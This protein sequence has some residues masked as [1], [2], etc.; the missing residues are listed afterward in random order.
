MVGRLA[1]VRLTVGVRIGVIRFGSRVAVRVSV[2]AMI[3]VGLVARGVNKG[4]TALA[5]AVCVP[6]RSPTAEAGRLQAATTR[7][8]PNT[9]G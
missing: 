1:G 9:A 6:A 3:G 2:L 7:I 5:M 4:A 8:I